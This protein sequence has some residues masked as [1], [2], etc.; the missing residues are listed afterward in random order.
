MTILFQILRR[1]FLGTLGLILIISISGVLYLES[2]LPSVDMLKDMR[3]QVPLKVFSQ[4]GKLIAEFGEG[5]RTPIELHQ[6]PKDLIHAILAT[7][8]RRFY[9]HPGVDFRGL[10]RAG[11]TLLT[12]SSFKQGGS[13][14]TMQVARNFF[15]SRKKTF[16][17]KIS[18]ILLALKIE[19]GLT[20]DEILELYLNKIYF[21][22]RAYGV[23]AAAEAYYGITVDKLTLDQM[24]MLAG[25]PQAPSSINPLHDPSAAFKR[26]KHVLDRML[27]YHFITEAQYKASVDAPLPTKYHGRAIEIEAPYIAEMVRQ[28]LFSRYGEAIYDL[29]YEVHTTIDSQ[30]QHAANQALK[31]ALLEYDQRHGYRKTKTHFKLSRH[32]TPEQ[33]IHNWSRQLKSIP[34]YSHLLPGVV[35]RILDNQIS[36]LLQDGRYIDIPWSGLSWAR[37]QLSGYRLGHFPKKPSDVV[38]IG[39][40]I[41]TEKLANQSWKMSQVP[42][43]GGALI[44]LHPDSGSILALVGGFDYNLSSFN[45]VTQAQRQPGS[46]FKPFL[47]AAALSEGYTLA[48]VVNDA[49]LVYTDPVTNVTWRPQNDSKTFYGPTRLRLSLTRSQNMVTI[50]LLQAIG[51]QKFIQFAEKFGFDPA[52]LPPYLSMA[53]GSAEVTPLELAS[54]YCVFANGG[55]KVTPSL[56]HKI[57]DYQGNLI[58]EAKAPSTVPAI[59][60]Q[61]AFLVTSALQ[62]AIQRGTGQRAKSL[63]RTDLAGKTGTTNEWMDAWYSGYNR[64]VVATAW[65]GFDEPKTLREYGSMAALPMWMYFMDA[66]LKGKPEQTVPPPPGIVS[67]KID[68]ATGLLAREG[69]DNAIPEFFTESNLPKQTAPA[70]IFDENGEA[71][72]DQIDNVESLF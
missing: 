41:Y 3:L 4:D 65:V 2:T 64:N 16:S 50:R 56:I 13:T 9:E 14:I 47:Y 12:H 33:E 26:R 45:R 51:V 66:L 46:N 23:V 59:S 18:E 58:Y 69:Q 48:S 36:V 52:K 24:A 57:T 38:S 39:D 1:S 5:R 53:L 68:P 54:G 32:K 11:V 49:P 42:E 60:P 27:T 25:L 40:V 30:H 10:A 72:T 67:V 63:G 17:R 19:K 43:V 55:N 22:K 29:G 71:I 70:G 37:P 62:D 7:E 35:V 15:L 31:R 28:E 6:I 34:V 8:D 21:G 20:K 61:V 44:A